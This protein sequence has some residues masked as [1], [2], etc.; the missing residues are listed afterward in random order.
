MATRSSAVAAEPQDRVLVIERI[1]EAPRELIFKC[2]RSP[3]TWSGC[4]RKASPA[5]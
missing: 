1:F 5:A 3:S 4:S 2:F